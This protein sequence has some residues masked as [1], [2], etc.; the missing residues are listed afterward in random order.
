[1]TMTDDDIFQRLK[2]IFIEEFELEPEQLIPE[3]TLFDDLGLDSLDAVD[4]V[5]ALEKEFGVKVKDEES[6]RSV[7]TLDDLHQLLLAIHAQMTDRDK[8][9][10]A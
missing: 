7:R 1:M 3:A 5:V 2:L 4:M 9:T 10:A 8:E 6:I